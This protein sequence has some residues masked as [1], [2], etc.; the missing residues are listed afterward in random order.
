MAYLARQS[1]Y[2]HVSRA[3]A[4]SLKGE[5]KGFRAAGKRILKRA[6][7]KAS[8]KRKVPEQGPEYK[9]IEPKTT[10]PLP[11]VDDFFVK[12]IEQRKQRVLEQE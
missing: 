5:A 1:L 7:G 8:K 3:A 9:R 10:A 12:R 6:L 4:S 2:N 11:K